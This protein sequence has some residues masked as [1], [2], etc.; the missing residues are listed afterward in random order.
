MAGDG[1]NITRVDGEHPTAITLLFQQLRNRRPE[2]QRALRGTLQKTGVSIVRGHVVENEITH[3]N[4]H[5]PKRFVV[6]GVC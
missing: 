2:L 1:G 4:L 5:I 6:I 3:I